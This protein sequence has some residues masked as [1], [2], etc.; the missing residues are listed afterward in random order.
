CG[1]FPVEIQERI[2]G[3]NLS[4]VSLEE[5]KALYQTLQSKRAEGIIH[6]YRTVLAHKF[7]ALASA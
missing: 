4:H 2:L 5:G 7:D 6:I 1:P 3:I